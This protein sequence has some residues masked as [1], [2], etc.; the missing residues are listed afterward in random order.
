MIII[1]CDKGEVLFDLYAVFD[2]H[3]SQSAA[4]YCKNEILNT[5]LKQ[6]DKDAYA[7]TVSNLL[8]IICYLLYL[9]SKYIQNKTDADVRKEIPDPNNSNNFSPSSSND[10]GTDNNKYHKYISSKNNESVKNINKYNKY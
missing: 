6:L 10:K 5:L 2:G 1:E 4:N 8:F 9:L 3:G 7:Y